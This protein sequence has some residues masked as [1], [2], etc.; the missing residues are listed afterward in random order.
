M[1]V[2]AES[3]WSLCTPTCTR[4]VAMCVC[5]GTGRCPRV[6]RMLLLL[7]F[8]GRFPR[9]G[10]AARDFMCLFLR[11]ARGPAGGETGR[12]SPGPRPT[13]LISRHA[14]YTYV[15]TSATYQSALGARAAH[16]C[17]AG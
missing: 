16:P 11:R 3:V 14:M 4:H 17:T 12:R 9:G 10:A 5:M 1:C 7:I 13:R 15:H 6:E 2:C 8:A